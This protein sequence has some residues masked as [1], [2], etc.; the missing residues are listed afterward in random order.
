MRTRDEYVAGLKGRLDRWNAD[1]GK[2]EA[3][4]RVAH[5]DM[6]KRYDK[7]LETLRE[8]REEALYNLNLVEKA[9]A[10]AWQDLAKGADEAWERMQE[11]FATARS[12]FEKQPKQ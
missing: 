11:A 1:A 12:H 2:W 3:Q 6:K 7:Q 4:A 5:A 10:T 8:R 9:S